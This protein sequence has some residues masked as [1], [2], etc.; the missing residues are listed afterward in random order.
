MMYRSSNPISKTGLSFGARISLLP[1]LLAVLLLNRALGAGESFQIRL[2]TMGYLPNAE[3]K[4]SIAAPCTNFTVVRLP[5]HLP[6]FSGVVTGPVLNE[7]TK[8]QL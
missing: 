7:D 1:A 6:V 5:S 3:K 4:A 2:N 8:E